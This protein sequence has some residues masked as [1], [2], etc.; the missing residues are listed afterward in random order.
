MKISF[1]IILFT[2]ATTLTSGQSSVQDIR[3]PVYRNFDTIRIDSNRT[4]ISFE[5]H[6]DSN[7]VQSIQAYFYASSISY[8]QFYIFNYF[9]LWK[10]TVNADSIVRH[11][12]S[13]TFFDSG[14]IE[15][16]IYDN[17]DLVSTEYY[18]QDKE[19]ISEEEFERRDNEIYAIITKRRTKR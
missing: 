18:N 3:I 12:I 19:P 16:N 4:L 1:I 11:G 14:D 17:G 7:L 15:V 5:A 8:Y 10:K 9:P 6:R 13:K 2:I